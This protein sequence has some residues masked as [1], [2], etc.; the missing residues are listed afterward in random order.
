M[1]QPGARCSEV[2]ALVGLLDL[3]GLEHALLE[4]F[5]HLRLDLGLVRDEAAEGLARE[6]EE[7]SAAGSPR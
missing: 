7:A 4:R 2:G 6:D 1:A 5:E 3:A